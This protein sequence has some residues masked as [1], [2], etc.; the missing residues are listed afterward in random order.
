MVRDLLG[1]ETVMVQPF[2][3]NS[4]LLAKGL[5]DWSVEAGE[6]RRDFGIASTNYGPAF[7]TA[8][9]RHGYSDTLTLEGRTEATKEAGVI[10]LGAVSV[11]PAQL[12]GKLAL[13]AS[14]D[15]SAGSGGQ[16]LVGLEHQGLRDS[17]AI[18]AQGASGG[19]RQL[20]MTC[21][22]ALPSCR[23]RAT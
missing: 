13:V 7:A 9:W 19:F 5:N 10:G 6:V 2:F 12:L 11:L 14:H 23:S 8:T 22:S 16:W 1:R 21:R 4:Q 20:G 17:A 18:Q 3:A 15:Q